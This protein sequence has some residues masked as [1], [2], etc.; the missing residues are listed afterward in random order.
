MVKQI[1]NTLVL[2]TVSTAGGATGPL[3]EAPVAVTVGA[4]GAVYVVDARLGR[5][6]K[7]DL[8]IR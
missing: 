4:D 8:G 7:L 1:P 2:S 6:L 3:F 5:V